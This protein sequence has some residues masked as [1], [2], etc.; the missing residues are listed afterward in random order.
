MNEGWKDDAGKPRLDLLPSELVLAIARVLT[1]GA[2]T[3]ESIRLGAGGNIHTNAPTAIAQIQLI[4][5]LFFM[6]VTTGVRRCG[7]DS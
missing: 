3:A 2:T 5:S 1:F 6:F 7:I 4:M